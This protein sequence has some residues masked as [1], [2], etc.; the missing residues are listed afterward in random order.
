MARLMRFGANAESL[1][2]R[3]DARRDNVCMSHPDFSDVSEILRVLSL[4]EVDF[5]V[6][7]AFVSRLRDVK[8][9]MDQLDTSSEPWVAKWLAAEHLKGGMLWTAAKTNW[10]KEQSDGT[11]RTFNARA[12]A[13]LITRFNGW[14]ADIRQRIHSYEMSDRS[15]STVAPWVAELERFREDPMHNS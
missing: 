12:R 1:R 15:A 13:A 2:T 11:D 14:V 10:V 5:S 6:G 3:I 8:V 9:A 7:D 4:H